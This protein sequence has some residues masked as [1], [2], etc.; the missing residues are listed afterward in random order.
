VGFATGQGIKD[1]SDRAR[2][3][4]VTVF[5]PT[6]P[7]PLTGFIIMVPAD[8][9]IPVDMSVEEAFRYCIT[10]GMLVPRRQAL[11]E[12]HLAELEMMNEMTEG[13]AEG[14][15]ADTESE[16]DAERDGTDKQEEQ[17][18]LSQSPEQAQGEN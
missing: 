3:E 2:R 17:T 7:T 4:L 16:P 5:I 11:S 8:E 10:A 1:I 9:V 14:S 15:D 18:D 6:S 13:P 12:E